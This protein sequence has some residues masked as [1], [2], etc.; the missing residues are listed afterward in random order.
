[1]ASPASRILDEVDPPVMAALVQCCRHS[2][3]D[4]RQHDGSRP[5]LGLQAEAAHESGVMHRAL[6]P[7]NV[8]AVA[9]PSLWSAILPFALSSSPLR[10]ELGAVWVPSS[11]ALQSNPCLAT[12]PV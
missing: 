3:R 5:E 11:R 8:V 4:R 6:K 10:V 9:R 1:M 7:A 12:C 2:G